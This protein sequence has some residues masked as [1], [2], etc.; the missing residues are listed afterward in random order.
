MAPSSAH[1]R[2]Q[3]DRVFNKVAVPSSGVT[4]YRPIVVPFGF[5]AH[6]SVQV[7]TCTGGA[8]DGNLCTA[9]TALADC[10]TGITC[11]GHTINNITRE[12]VV[13][14]FGGNATAWTDLGASYS[15]S[16]DSSNSIVAC[17]RHAGSGTHSTLD[18]AIMRAQ[19]FP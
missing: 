7:T 10:G 16:G 8:N 17:M 13:N 2:P 11:D 14:I 3:T 9:G 1:G 19:A 18:Y 6:N 5:Y 4:T 12:M 15:V